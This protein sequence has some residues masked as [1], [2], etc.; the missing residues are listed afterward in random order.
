VTDDPFWNYD[1]AYVLGALPPDERRRYERHL[2]H[3]RRCARA[4]RGLS[5]LPDLLAQ[6]DIA[7]P[8]QAAVG[9]SRKTAPVRWYRCQPHLLIAV[10][11]AA[12]ACVITAITLTVAVA[13]RPH[14]PSV[15]APVAMTHVVPAPI[16]A[17]AQLVDLAWGTRIEMSC[18]YSDPDGDRLPASYLL[19]AVDRS[20]RSQQLATWRV[21]P[22]TVSHI[23]A[24]TNLRRTDIKSLEV[25]TP[26]GQP[27]LQLSLSILR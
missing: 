11:L 23:S 3:C 5:G 26:A 20:G 12:A 18:S 21:V 19:V 2:R 1:G 22:G 17:D 16:D 9:A 4:T 24:T 10:M 6:A 15:A 7:R 25:S 13:V 27:V 14:G 8:D